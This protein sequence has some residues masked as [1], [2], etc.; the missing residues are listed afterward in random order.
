LDF[1]SALDRLDGALRPCCLVDQRC[2]HPARVPIIFGDYLYVDGV[3]HIAEDYFGTFTFAPLVGLVMGLLQ[4]GLLRRHLPRMERWVLATLGGWL[5]GLFLI[6]IAAMLNSWTYVSIDLDLV[7]IL[8]GLSIGVG[9]WL[10]LQARLSRAGWW[11]GANVLGWGMTAL[12]TGQ[13]FG[14]GG[15]FAL[16]IYLPV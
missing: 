15:I 2:Y 10:L 13:D 9:Q 7:L 16:G 11:I 6:L 4:Y 14:E 12:L 3:A 1:L 5:L 8:F